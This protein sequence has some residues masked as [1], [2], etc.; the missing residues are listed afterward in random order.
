MYLF[1]QKADGVYTVPLFQMGIGA[2]YM[3]VKGDDESIR[4]ANSLPDYAV[5]IQ[6]PAMY[7]KYIF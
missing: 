4:L 3:H 7:K 5:S 1:Q 2:H 6:W